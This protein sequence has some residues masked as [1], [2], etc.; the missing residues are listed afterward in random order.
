M[1]GQAASSFSPYGITFTL[2][3]GYCL[4]LR[5]GGGMVHFHAK[6]KNVL[7]GIA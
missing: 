4:L 7:D 5:G 1:G 6:A 3:H 2:C